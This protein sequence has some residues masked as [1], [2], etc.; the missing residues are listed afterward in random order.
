MVSGVISRLRVYLEPAVSATERGQAFRRRF[1]RAALVCVAA[2]AT[3]LALGGLAFAL[4]DNVLLLMLAATVG[5]ITF[6]PPV[7]QITVNGPRPLSIT[8]TYMWL[9]ISR[10]GTVVEVL[11]PAMLTWAAILRAISVKALATADSGSPTTMGRPSSPPRRT[12]ER[13]V[14]CCAC[15]DD[16]ILRMILAYFTLQGKMIPALQ[17][18]GSVI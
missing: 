10:N 1:G 15:G 3:G 18:P 11:P 5:V 8:L 12:T 16:F 17:K 14:Q 9:L 2:V 7:S 6:E 4:T 13:G